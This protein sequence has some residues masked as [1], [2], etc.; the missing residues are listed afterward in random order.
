MMKDETIKPAGRKE[1]MKRM[2]KL[3]KGECLMFQL[4]PTYGG[5][6]VILELNPSFPDN[7]EKKYL[8]RLGKTEERALEG[9]AFH[10]SDRAKQMAVWVAERSARWLD[11]EKSQL[12]AA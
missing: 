9:D 11:N 3:Q 2:E 4:S 7:G 5:Q 12:E 1:I 6:I 8:I 10:S